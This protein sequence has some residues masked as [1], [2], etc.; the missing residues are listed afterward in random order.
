MIKTLYKSVGVGLVLVLSV[1]V[2]HSVS[3]NEV[4]G[5]LS[6][7]SVILDAGHGG[8]AGPGASNV[9][10]GVTVIEAEVNQAVVQALRAQLESQGADVIETQ[11]QETRRERVKVAIEQC[12]TDL[13]KK[14]DILVSVHHNGSED[15]LHDGTTTIH[16]E[17]KDIPLALDIYQALTTGL[18]LPAE[19]ILSGG[20]GMTVYGNIVSAATEAYYITNDCE[21]QLYLIAT[22][23]L[24]GLSTECAAD[25]N[26]NTVVNRIDQEAGLLLGGIMAYFNVGP[27]TPSVESVSVSVST[28]QTSYVYTG[29]PK[30]KK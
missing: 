30:F 8:D 9:I 14:C 7:K 16:N 10:G 2:G 27:V 4:V 13:G 26:Y 19:A 21:A 17:K 15:P 28:N 23:A 5:P 3:A 22:G 11:R 12:N 25:S 6:G 24:V 1:M 29:G 18:G 20:Y